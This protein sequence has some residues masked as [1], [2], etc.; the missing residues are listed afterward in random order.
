MLKCGNLRSG[1]QEYRAH[2]YAPMH[3]GRVRL[4]YPH[5]SNK[6]ILVEVTQVKYLG[7]CI[8][9][10]LDWEPHM[11]SNTSEAHQRLGFVG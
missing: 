9:S 8:F 7:I 6:D 5:Q 2:T 3:I 11:S 10:D 4:S 1:A